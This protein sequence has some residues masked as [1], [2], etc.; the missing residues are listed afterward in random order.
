MIELR[1]VERHYAGP[2]PRVVLR[3]VHLHV[4]S[5]EMV[6]I[7]G[8]SGSGKSTLLNI[9]A[10]LERPDA[11][12]VTV[13]GVALAALDDDALTRFR[14]QQI[15]F[16]FQAFH[17]LPYLSVGDNVALPLTLQGVYGEVSR[18]RVLAMLDSVGLAD[19]SGSPPRELSGGE[20]QRVAI[21]RALV[22]RPA[23]VL[24]DEP[25]GNLDPDSAAEI[26]T[27]LRERMAAEGA[28]GV[29][30]THS[31]LRRNA[32]I[33]CSRCGQARWYL[34][35]AGRHEPGAGT[36]GTGWCARPAPRPVGAGH[37]GH[38]AGGRAGFCRGHHQCDR[39]ERVRKWH[40]H[41][42]WRGR[43]RDPRCAQWF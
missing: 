2:R 1:A 4:A 25:T 14:R 32:R 17:V 12:A 41:A 7:R 19:R 13:A 29:L 37:A 34:R 38:R 40:A 26:I 33:A 18:T 15:G 9:I 16:V 20:L 27:L 21:A 11:G 39:G 6:A 42:C 5:G 35:G 30:V 28:C 43:P 31:T 10:G 22:H 24:A 23:I 3:E 36:R 8:E